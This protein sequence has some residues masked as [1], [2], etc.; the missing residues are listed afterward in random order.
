MG[1]GVALASLDRIARHLPTYATTSSVARL[2][3]PEVRMRHHVLSWLPGTSFGIDLG[4]DVRVAVGRLTPANPLPEAGADLVWSGDRRLEPHLAEARPARVNQ[5]L[6][7]RP[8]AASPWWGGARH[9]EHTVVPRDLEAFVA[10]LTDEDAVS[11]TCS[12]CGEVAADHCPFC[13]S[14][15]GVAA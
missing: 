2:A 15:E 12:Q 4:S 9:Y 7:L 14:S 10:S 13:Q 5:T 11:T 6:E 1:A 3:L 8:E